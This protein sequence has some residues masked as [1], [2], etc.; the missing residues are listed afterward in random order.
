MEDL[1]ISS[2][3]WRGCRVLLTGHTGFKGA[4]MALLLHRLGAHV[5]GFA[6]PPLSDQGVFVAAGVEN[7]VRHSIGDIR[8]LATVRRAF[9]DARPHIVLHMAAQS[10]V[11]PSY[12]DPVGT[13]AVN[14]MG[15]VNVLECIRQSPEVKAA[16]IV[17]SDKCYDNV[18]QVWG[19]RETESLGGHDPYSNSKACAELVIDAYRRS[20]LHDKSCPGVA[21]ARAG[22][23]IGGGDWAQDRLVPDAM[24]AFLAGTMLD[25]RNPHAVRPWQH[26]LDPVMAY[27]LLAERVVAD[28][29]AFA[30]AWNFG[31]ASE[32]EV[33]VA[34]I[35]DM[36]ARGWSEG[37]A[38]KRDEG[39][40]PREAAF[41]KLDC[42]KAR[43]HLDWRPMLDLERAVHLTLD[44]Y[45][46]LQRGADMRAFTLGQID[47]VVS[48][49][50]V[51]GEAA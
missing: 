50:L 36:L 29:R 17:T 51:I 43:T 5:H 14:V 21:S 32:S 45:K 44:W 7:D 10:L 33:S 42:S 26:V 49:A 47:E 13:Y 6:L 27:L 3:F 11:H 48:P 20:F 19:Y 2:S 4:W 15:T 35:V 16:V 9:D 24:R 28:G 8:D 1:V 40:H 23:V 34:Q 38:W 25:V 31:P 39:E 12:A 30:Q 41:L 22:N 46:A 37:A 18:G